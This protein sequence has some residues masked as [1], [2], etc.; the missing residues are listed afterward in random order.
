MSYK[1]PHNLTCILLQQLHQRDFSVSKEDIP[2]RGPQTS[3]KRRLAV[4]WK[5]PRGRCD[6]PLWD[7]MPD[8]DDGRPLCQS[9]T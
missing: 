6:I 5:A 2:E 7:L 8:L 9:L 3:S 1:Y 4:E